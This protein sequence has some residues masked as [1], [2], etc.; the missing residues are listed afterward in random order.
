MKTKILTIFFLSALYLGIFLLSAVGQPIFSA[1]WSN[2]CKCL[3]NANTGC[4]I[5][6]NQ[7][8]PDNKQA[9]C[10]A[11]SCDGSC[12]CVAKGSTPIPIPTLP[13]GTCTCTKNND[14]CISDDNC[15]KVA[16]YDAKCN[17]NCTACSCIQ[18]QNP[19]CGGKDAVCCDPPDEECYPGLNLIC[20]T[21]TQGRFCRGSD[22]Q[23][24][25]QFVWCDSKNGRTDVVTGKLYTA[26][27]CIPTDNFNDF[28][29]WLLSKL[30]F[31][32][33]GIA[34]LLMVLGA[35]Q[36]LTSAGNPD[37]VKAGKELITSALSGLLFII[38]SVFLLKLIGV[39]ILH[40]P[41][42]GN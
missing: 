15:N 3:Y 20:V 14:Q 37:K 12:E 19:L 26:I 35:I 23:Y 11:D 29:G 16:G 10:K 42:L 9:Q 2:T 22:F 34:F 18:T 33:S 25:R 31:V 13:P 28:I 40:I 36:I 7:C 6:M 21:E 39:D 27:G 38:L 32:A 5:T 30:I 24:T 4:T 8:N 17:D 41:G 1:E